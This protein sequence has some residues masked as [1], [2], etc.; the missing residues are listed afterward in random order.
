MAELVADWQMQMLNT[1]QLKA[2]NDE[3]DVEVHV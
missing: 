3:A 2:S 1:Q